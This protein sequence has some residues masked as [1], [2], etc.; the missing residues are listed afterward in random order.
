HGRRGVRAFDRGADL[1]VHRHGERVLLLRPV[2]PHGAD[3]A[4]VADE[5]ETGHGGHAKAAAGGIAAA[6]SVTVAARPGVAVARFSAKKRATA[7][8][9]GASA[10][11]ASRS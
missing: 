7:M 2:H 9:A 11:P 3:R 5:D 10:S 4:V 1:L 8:R 6:P